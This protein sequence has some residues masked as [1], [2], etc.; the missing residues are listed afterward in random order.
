MIESAGLSRPPISLLIASED[1]SGLHDALAGLSDEEKA[2]ALSGLPV[3]DR[4][5]FFKLI[6]PDECAVLFSELDGAVLAGLVSDFPSDEIADVLGSLPEERRGD[7]LGRFPEPLRRRV[8]RLLTYGKD[9][10]G[11]IMSGDFIA[12]PDAATVGE[13]IEGLRKIAPE[14]E[15]AFYVYV[16]DAQQK[17]Q[18][19]LSM[20]DLVLRPSETPLRQILRAQIVTVAPETDQEEVARIFQKHR[21]LALPVVDGQRA[22]LGVITA[23]DVAGVIQQEAME[24]VLKLS[25]LP[26]GEGSIHTPFSL[27][28]KK[29][30]P[31]LALNLLLDC[32][33]VSVV[34]YYQGTIQAIVAVAVLL[35]I[36]SDMGGNMGLQNLSLIVR[37]LATGEV[38]LKDFGKIAWRQSL[39]GLTMGLFLGLQVAL[40]AYLW[41]GKPLLGAVA[42]LAMFFNIAVAALIG[43][44]LPLVLKAVRLDPAIATGPVMTTMTDFFGFFVTLWLT[45]RFLPY[46]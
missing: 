1:R 23:E 24:D 13:V 8:R 41:Q 3:S 45:S 18:G 16:V 37:G 9:T 32:A 22:L 5:H 33:A 40:L 38:N 30:L 20:R 2:A 14:Q 7:V 27:A 31:W 34:A 43:A 28:I 39:L 36:I 11:G 6:P 10:A 4:R 29:R 46:L 19:V 26:S 25:G 12:F 17:L 35:P 15:R 42:G 21:L 44:A